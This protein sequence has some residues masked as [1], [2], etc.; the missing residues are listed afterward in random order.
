MRLPLIRFNTRP[1]HELR[2]KT[3]RCRHTAHRH[4]S[5]CLP[6]HI[7]EDAKR[8]FAQRRHATSSLRR[9]LIGLQN[10][11]F[12]C[13]ASS[14]ASHRRWFWQTEV[15]C[16]Q[17]RQVYLPARPSQLHT[18]WRDHL[19]QRESHSE[20]RR[21]TRICGG[22]DGAYHQRHLSQMPE[23]IR[24]QALLA[25]TPSMR[26]VAVTMMLSATSTGRAKCHNLIRHINLDQIDLFVLN[27]PPV[28]FLV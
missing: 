8:L 25:Q 23:V 14:P 7:R 22:R 6:N 16:L 15:L 19:S 10:T 2:T 21:A 4:P 1:K 9:Q 13:R 17:V 24:W 18:L 26:M 5:A 28:P 27:I 12:V 20:G 3:D 11:I